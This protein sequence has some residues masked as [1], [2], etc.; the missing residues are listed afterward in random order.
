MAY[1]PA[2]GSSQLDARFAGEPPRLHVLGLVVW[3]ASDG[4]LLPRNAGLSVDYVG[5]SSAATIH[6]SD[7]TSGLLAA[8]EPA[9]TS[10]DW[11][12]DGVR[13]SDALWLSD[14][15]A[16]RVRDAVLPTLHWSMG[17][18]A[19]LYEWIEHGNATVEGAP[20]WSFTTD[21]VD[22][23]YLALLG[24]GDGHVEFVHHNGAGTVSAAL[25]V[26]LGDRCS[27]R[28]Q[29]FDDGS[30]ELSLVRNSARIVTH[31]DRSE[32]LAPAATWG[33]GGD[34]RFRL[35]E[36]GDAVRGTQYARYLAMYGGVASHT[37]LLEVL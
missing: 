4:E 2:L 15:E 34:T 14:E 31:S 10:V 19:G 37:Q 13:E 30:V 9:F 27:L 3:R 24:S 18:K 36:F 11:D 8:A 20:Y 29:Y 32:P 25:P 21:A 35:N 22:G 26:T 23:A 17:A 16:L 6:A 5:R 1:H 33:D 7:G 12:G 28:H